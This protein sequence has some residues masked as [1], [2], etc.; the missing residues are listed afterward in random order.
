[1]RTPSRTVTEALTPV[2]NVA[3][4]AMYLRQ[5]YDEHGTWGEAVRRYHSGDPARGD[6]YLRRVLALWQGDA[7]VVAGMPGRMVSADH[8]DSPHHNAATHLKAGNNAVAL[9]IYAGILD[10][11][12]DDR[13]ALAGKALALEGLGR[14]RQARRCVA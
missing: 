2:E 1:M 11:N 8:R 3:Y 6:A 13:T 9:D 14:P 12:G 10:R 7:E 4:G 5:L